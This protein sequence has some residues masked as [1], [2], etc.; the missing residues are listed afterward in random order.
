MLIV[1]TQK[2]SFVFD[3]KKMVFLDFW[4][5]QMKLKMAVI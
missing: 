5:K 2:N 4:Q 3:F 1:Q